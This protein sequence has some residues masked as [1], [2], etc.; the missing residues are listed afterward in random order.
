MKLVIA[1]AL[2][3]RSEGKNNLIAAW[4]SASSALT[5]FSELLERPLEAET[6]LVLLGIYYQRGKVVDTLQAAKKALKIYQEIKDRKGEARALHGLGLAASLTGDFDDAV[7]KATEALQIHRELGDER[8][9]AF[10]LQALSQWHLAQ[11]ILPKAVI[12][13]L[14]AVGLFGS[15]RNGS[16]GEV[17]AILLGAEAMIANGRERQALKLA[18]EGVTRFRERQDQRGLTAAL[19][20]VAH[21]SL[22]L[23]SHDVAYQAVTEALATAR[24]LHDQRLEIDM[25][26]L[27]SKFYLRCNQFEDALQAMRSAMQIAQKLNDLEE[28]AMALRAICNIHM[29]MGDI[30]SDTTVLR[31]TLQCA[32]DAKVLFK[33]SG[34]LS[35]EGSCA[36]ILATLNESN[37]ELLK[38]AREAQSIFQQAEDATGESS[39]WKLIIEAH[40]LNEAHEEALSAAKARVDLWKK[41]GKKDEEADALLKLA[42]IH[43]SQES[44]DEAEELALEAKTCSEEAKNQGIEASALLLLTQ[45]YVS[46]MSKEDLPK[47]KDAALPPEFIRTREKAYR[48]VKEALDLACKTSDR[49]LRATVLFWRAEVFIWTFRGQEA[50]SSA[51]LADKM[52]AK[53]GNLSGQVH[54]QVLMADLHLMMAQKD[55][56]K[57]VAQAALDLATSMIDGEDEEAACLAVLERISGKK[58]KAPVQAMQQVMPEEGEEQQVQA[59]IPQARSLAIP[60]APK[61]LDIAVTQ[62]KVLN[63]AKNVIADDDMELEFDMP[64]MESGVDSLGSVQLVTDL[65]KEFAMSISP[66][67]IFDFPTI[68]QLAEHLVE[69]YGS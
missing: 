28:E 24:N 42:G 33:R 21:I 22:T 1:E 19:E 15:M 41:W 46:S 9:Q 11:K 40:V 65:G 45:V 37:T 14:E 8:G 43:F 10:E 5:A 55:K 53:M 68:R 34:N 61:G 54:T 18:K 7:S 26:H 4:E 17:V 51:E 39:A 50:L 13:A 27:A 3:A 25:L 64:L 57:A 63:L 48:S 29:S 36:I 56:A 31:D 20:V 67:A 66:S 30:R 59:F 12:C 38:R 35:G 49:G 60:E 32:E 69:E 6:Y 62:A 47:N 2:A 58:D 23:G 16:R 44:L 52:F